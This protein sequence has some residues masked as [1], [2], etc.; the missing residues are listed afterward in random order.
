MEN[1]IEEIKKSIKKAHQFSQ[2]LGSSNS[3]SRDYLVGDI[4]NF[5][6]TD[7]HI[8]LLELMDKKYIEYNENTGVIIILKSL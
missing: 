8:A 7:I 5:S 1:I 2:N 3:I 4:K 6:A